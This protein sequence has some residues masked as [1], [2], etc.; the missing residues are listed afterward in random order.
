MK[1][2]R[3]KLNSKLS[4]NGGFTLVEMLIVVAIIAI[5]IM[6]SIPMISSNLEKAREATD[7]ANLRSAQSLATAYYLTEKSDPASTAVFA[8]AGTEYAYK[9]DDN[10][11][12][13]SIIIATSAT[14]GNAGFKY[15]RAKGH[16]DG[17]V[18][19]KINAA[20]EVSDAQWV[21][22]T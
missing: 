19:L 8:D 18:K 7:S 13:G 15:G 4:N 16:V 21:P 22:K 14:A 6:V 1:K 3:E 12:Q 10:S 9:V 17:Y 2:L 5:L 20:G 11:H